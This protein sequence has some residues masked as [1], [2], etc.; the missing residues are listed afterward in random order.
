MVLLQ[1]VIPQ[2]HHN[3]HRP[4]EGVYK[5]LKLLLDW[6]LIKVLLKSKANL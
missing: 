2:G 6:I 3:G 5:L 1:V 4:L